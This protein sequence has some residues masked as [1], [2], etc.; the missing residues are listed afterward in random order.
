MT[1]TQDD[2][3]TS[4]PLA[5]RVEIFTGAGRRRSWSAEDKARIVAEST[6]SGA[7]V[8]TDSTHRWMKH[9]AQV[10]TG[11]SVKAVATGLPAERPA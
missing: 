2:P 3:R 7:N 1:D 9:R 8:P 10:T 5:R 6:A 4:D 11:N